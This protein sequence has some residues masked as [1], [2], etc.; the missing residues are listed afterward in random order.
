MDSE[1]V[2]TR[3]KDP[4]TSGIS[5]LIASFVR[6]FSFVLRVI[7]VGLLDNISH[8][9]FPEVQSKRLKRKP[10]SVIHPSLNK[11]TTN[12]KFIDL[13]KIRGPDREETTGRKKNYRNLTRDP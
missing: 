1:V 11:H 6:G 5:C 9:I 13:S 12:Y 3:P 4:V 2:Y 7:Y 8:N 10:R